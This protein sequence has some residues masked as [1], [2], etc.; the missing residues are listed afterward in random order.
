MNPRQA[1]AATTHH[2]SPVQLLQKMTWLFIVQGL[3]CFLM[4]H[5][6]LGEVNVVDPIIGGAISPLSDASQG[7]GNRSG[8]YIGSDFCICR[9]RF[10]FEL[11]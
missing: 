10:L 6:G 8:R 11:V 2:L 5:R 9:L 4:T 7:L 1:V 3:I